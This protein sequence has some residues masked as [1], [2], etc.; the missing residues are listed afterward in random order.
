MHIY[1]EFASFCRK[2]KKIVGC[3]HFQVKR[4]D[5]SHHVRIQFQVSKVECDCVDD[6]IRTVADQGSVERITVLRRQ[7]NADCQHNCKIL[8]EA[9]P[10]LKHML[11]KN[12]RIKTKERIFYTHAHARTRLRFLRRHSELHLALQGWHVPQSP[13]PNQAFAAAGTL[14]EREGIKHTISD[15][16][17]HVST[18]NDPPPQ[19]LF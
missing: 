17:E 15:A 16:H 9:F 3:A 11:K 18:R 12:L 2:L 5:V 4:F 10:F 19:F 13:S 7:V 1:R 14:Q 6:V 8:V